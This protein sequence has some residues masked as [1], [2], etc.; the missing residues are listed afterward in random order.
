MNEEMNEH[1][2]MRAAQ[3]RAKIGARKVKSVHP[4]EPPPVNGPED[5]GF[6]ASSTTAV[7]GVTLDDFHAYMPQ[8]SY[9]FAPTCEMW[10]AASVNARVP[11]VKVSDSKSITPTGWLD[12][13]KP[14]ER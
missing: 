11:S 13:H 5:Y 2:A 4:P 9:I 8:H 10:A 3:M 1:I 14:I 12:R 7:E 6:E